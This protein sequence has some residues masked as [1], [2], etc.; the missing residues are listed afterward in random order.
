MGKICTTVLQFTLKMHL[1]WYKVDLTLPELFLKSTLFLLLKLSYGCQLY[2]CPL[3]PRVHDTPRSLC[4]QAAG[5]ASSNPPPS[6]SKLSGGKRAATIQK[7]AV[8]F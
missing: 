1:T 3:R 6:C 8:R 2:M 4:A 5:T 7:E